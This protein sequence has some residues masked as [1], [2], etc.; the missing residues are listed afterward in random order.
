M[1]SGEVAKKYGHKGLA[2]ET[3]NIK[4]E[5]TAGQALEH[6]LQKVYLLSFRAKVTI[7]LEKEFLEE[8]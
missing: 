7:M 3:I 1:L 6:F 5:G 2:D 8:G 4:L